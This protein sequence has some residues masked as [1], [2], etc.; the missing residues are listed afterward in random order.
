MGLDNLFS[1]LNILLVIGIA[2]LAILLILKLEKLKQLQATNQG[3]KK[4][5]NEMDE[6]AKLILRTD[7]ELNKAQEELDKKITSLYALQRMS[8]AI[9]STL[10]ENKIF[11][12]IESTGIEDFGFEKSCAFLWDPVKKAFLQQANIGYSQAE[13]ETIQSYLKENQEAYLELLS[14]KKTVSSLSLSQEEKSKINKVFNVISFVISSVSPIGGSRGFLFMGTTDINMA[15]SEGDEEMV[16]VLAH[17]IGQAID[18]ARLFE[19]TWHT[20]Q[21]L[22][23]K[24][25]ERTHDLT[26]AL[27][28][29][30]MIS[31]RKT[32]FVSAVSHELRT[33]LTSIKG[34]ASI[35]L[36]G[37][38]GGIPPEVQER[39]EKINSHSDELTHFV[40]DLLDIARIEAGRMNMKKET[41]DLEELLRRVLDLLAGQLKEK[42][43]ALSYTIPKEANAVFADR[44]QLNRVFINLIGNALKF[45]PQGGKINIYA[46]ISGNAVQIDISD[47]GC[48]MPHEAQQQIFEEFYRVDNTI[49]QEAKGTG[50]GL[51]LV[52]HIIEAHQGKIWVKSTVGSGS[53]FSFTLPLPA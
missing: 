21:Q 25:E 18:N 30:Q 41:F 7:I 40:N 47:T 46:K 3:L 42:N 45:T 27:E 50:L 6:Q 20:Q 48:G 16:T 28:E 29:V 13:L 36:A 33:P 35:L 9:S 8:R 31:K 44:G 15:I 23:R 5:L 14:S 51:S 22:E 19:K 34:Y 53:T 4:S 10:E 26:K 52:K 39:L 32:D 49:N 24:V 43:I 12:I 37:K 17:Q 11:K 1:I 38:L 2:A